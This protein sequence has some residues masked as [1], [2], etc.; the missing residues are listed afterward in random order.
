MRYFVFALFMFAAGVALTHVERDP[1]ALTPIVRVRTSEGLFVTYVQRAPLERS[2]CNDVVQ[3][4]TGAI[5]KAC[6]NCMV[7]S[8][9]CAIEL[10]GIDRALARNEPL[11]LYTVRSQAFRIG[12][13]GPPDAV[14]G[15]CTDMA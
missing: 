13:V 15:E 6:K 14:R 11:P 8:A 12:I 7:E 9:T 1:Q 5:T 3:A 10:E 4:F 2:I